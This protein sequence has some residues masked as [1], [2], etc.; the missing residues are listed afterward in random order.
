MA[1]VIVGAGGRYVGFDYSLAMTGDFSERAS[2]DYG[3][4]AQVVVGED[5]S[6]VLA[7]QTFDAILTV[8]VLIHND[9]REAKNLLG[10]FAEY[11]PAGGQVLLI[12]NQLTAVSQQENFWHG[13]CWSH[14]FA[15]LAGPYFDVEVDPDILSPQGL[16]RL[17]K[18]CPDSLA[19]QLYFLDW[20]ADSRTPSSLDGWRKAGEAQSNRVAAHYAREVQRLPLYA[21]LLHD[22][23]EQLEY[24]RNDANK[25]EDAAKLS[26]FKASEME[27]NLLVMK[28][29]LLDAKSKL[30]EQEK[31]LRESRD[32]LVRLAILEE[33]LRK[34][35]VV[36]RELVRI[37]KS[38]APPLEI[39]APYVSDCPE[40]GASNFEFDSLQDTRY[41]N[42]TSST[43][44]V[45][46]CF[47]KEWSGIR[48]AS[49]SLP[50]T[51][52][53]ISA[54]NELSTATLRECLSEL[55]ARRP[56]RLVFHG[57]SG[58]AAK[59]AEAAHRSLGL[60]TYLVWHGNAGQLWWE[61][62]RRLLCIAADLAQRG[63]FRRVHVLK[64]GSAALIPRARCYEPMLLN[65]PPRVPDELRRRAPAFKL[66]EGT[67]LIS[68]WSDY[69]K[70]IYANALAAEL[71]DA[72]TETYMYASW[73]EVSSRRF[74]KRKHIRYGGAD[75]HFAM[76]SS[77]DVS[78]NATLIDCH[79][80]VDLEALSVGTPIVIGPLFLD[81][82]ERHPITELC[83]VDNPLSPADIA[84]AINRVRS[85]ASE[86]EDLSRDYC[87]IVKALSAQRYGEFLEL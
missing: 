43:A 69:R 47:H 81:A 74:A 71:S 24:A 29:E 60:K 31:L 26:I 66:G 21:G 48:A 68:G 41:S 36:E 1:A 28:S 78:L 3:E 61:G 13:G 27:A 35:A 32:G 73:D 16:Y 75:A 22:A 23:Y 12:E 45:V 17:T 37:A 86:F 51:K 59:L 7:S 2:A 10:T 72:I 15:E 20:K 70:N 54:D 18:R 42:S 44:V 56:D 38:A 85:A 84:L 83:T 58:N 19:N 34:R 64:A 14:N 30:Q 63:V 52:L 67:A 62:E 57:M 39:P 79:P 55:S 4:L 33:S 9:S 53:C 40:S 8:S 82:L 5:V 46:H 77:V 87:E 49:G 11:L 76:M 65:P 6:D 80:M 50:G 25:H